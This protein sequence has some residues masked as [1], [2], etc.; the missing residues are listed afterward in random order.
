M[1]IVMIDPKKINASELNNIRE[2]HP[3]DPHTLHIK[4]LIKSKGF[5]PNRPVFVTPARNPETDEIIPDEFILCDGLHRTMIAKELG[6]KE[7]PCTVK[8]RLTPEEAQ[9][10]QYMLN[11][12]VPT[13]PREQYEHFKRYMLAHPTKTQSE[14]AEDFGKTPTDISKIMGYGKLTKSLQAKLDKGQITPSVGLT[15][16]RVPIQY[17][18][19]VANEVEKEGMPADAAIS[20]ITQQR[21]A[22]NKALREGKSKVDFVVTKKFVG[23]REAEA[24]L[25]HVTN[26]L[27][28]T[29]PETEDYLILTGEKQM[30]EKML[31]CDP[32][33][34]KQKEL[35]REAKKEQRSLESA[36][37]KLQ[38]QKEEVERLEA[39]LKRQKTESAAESL[40]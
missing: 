16:A 12:N 15:L 28:N 8:E 23:L 14:I 39:E 37:K 9:Q 27:K 3:D 18:E 21:K 24:M 33:T 11:T 35:A 30:A 1:Q 26:T 10:S 38:K 29:D 36:M 25:D 40:A 5:H 22:F 2:Y 13:K 32:E 20:Y 7:I 19:Q 31:S 34:L 6:L 17:Q 4:R